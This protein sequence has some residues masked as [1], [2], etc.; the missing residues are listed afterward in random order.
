LL[1]PREIEW[2]NGVLPYVA[3][4]GKVGCWILMREDS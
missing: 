3:V 1:I 4:V 2:A